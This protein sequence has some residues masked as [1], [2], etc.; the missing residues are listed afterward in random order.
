MKSITKK[1]TLL[2]AL[3][4]VLFLSSCLDS[5]SPHY[6][7]NDEISYIAIGETTGIVYARTLAGFAIT[8]PKIKQ[9]MPGSM[10]RISYQVK[11]EEDQTVMVDENQFAYVVELA[12]E[13]S[14]MQQTTL[15]LSLAPNVPAVKFESLMDPL[16]AQND[17]FGDRWIFTYYANIK[18]EDVNV[19]FYKA[20]DDDAKTANT[21]VLIDVRLEKTGTPDSGAT[22]KI[23]S[24]NIVVNLSALRML[25]ADEADSENKISIKF[26]YYRMDNEDIY[27]SN[28]KYLMHIDKE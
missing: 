27:I 11:T 9:L 17:Y 19:R 18:K 3:S 13:P 4:G 15:E 14:V 10:A 23:E 12:S 28:N 8:S 1:I 20:S 5:G 7:G 22:E 2:L 21:D 16:F 6:I 25:M 26:R 24:D